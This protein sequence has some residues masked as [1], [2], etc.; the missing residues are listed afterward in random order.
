MKLLSK[1]FQVVLSFSPVG[2]VLRVRARRFPA[3]INCTSIDWF[4]SWPQKA[5]LSVSDRFLQNIPQLRD[6]PSPA[7]S[8]KKSSPRSVKTPGAETAVDESGSP[9]EREL[10]RVLDK[11]DPVPSR[12]S[13]VASDAEKEAIDEITKENRNESPKQN[14]EEKEEK[15]EEE[16]KKEMK[17]KIVK[18]I[19]NPAAVRASVSQFMAYVHTS[20]NQISKSYFHV[21]V[22]QMSF[23]G[24]R[25]R[26][27]CIQF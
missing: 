23:E 25:F 5:L 13:S 8:R 22:S 3:I 26:N 14:N 10:R 19:S 15:F 2:S 27:I 20:V 16:E 17:T 9:I 4:H 18:S 7:S 1:T 6:A 24:F 12:A 21:R 11:N